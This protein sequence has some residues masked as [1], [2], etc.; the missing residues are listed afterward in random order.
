[1]ASIEDVVGVSGLVEARGAGDVD[2]VHAGHHVHHVVARAEE[3]SEHAAHLGGVCDIV[4]GLAGG[5]G[6]V[7]VPPVRGLGLR[8]VVGQG[9]VADDRHV[10]ALGDVA[11][12]A[13][14]ACATCLLG[15]AVST[16]HICCV[17]TDAYLALLHA[18]VQ[19][20]ALQQAVE[21][22]GA[23][24]EAELVLRVYAVVAQGAA[25]KGTEQPDE[26]LQ[27]LHLVG[28][29]CFQQRLHWGRHV[30]AYEGQGSMH[31]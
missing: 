15:V 26:G 18:G 29:R 21:V 13:A 12:C 27:T 16:S 19:Q 4:E 7:G 14:L 5:A 17:A 30:T 1:M 10:R 28:Y 11:R 23:R 9:P 24:K 31:A 22:G 20:V 3:L 25:H 6:E 8:G 2:L